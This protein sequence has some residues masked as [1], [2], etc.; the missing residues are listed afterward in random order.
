[1]TLPTLGQRTLAALTR[2]SLQ[3]WV[4]LPALVLALGA[5]RLMQMRWHWPA[6]LQASSAELWAVVLQGARFDLKVTASAALL[7]LPVFALVPGRLHARLA[8]TVAVLFVAASLVNLHY[9]GFYK[10]PIDAVVFGFFE[11][12]T[13]AILRT[14]WSDFPVFLTL[15]VL[16]GLSWFTIAGRRMLHDIATTTTTRMPAEAF[17]TPVRWVLVALSLLLLLL[18]MKGTL[19]AMP[20][21]RQN[22]T[23][24][25]SQFLNDMVPNGITALKFAWN[26]RRDSQNLSDPLVG[27]RAQ[28]YDS[29]QAAAQALGLAAGDEAALH[30]A[31]RMHA[32]ATAAPGA[33]KRKNLVLVL[34]E[35]WS[36]EPFLYQAADF[37]VLGRLAPTLKQGCHFS[38]FDAAQPGTHPTL[39]ALLFSTPI[40]PLTLGLQGRKPITWAVPH[41]LK[42]AGYHTLFVTSGRAGWR[43]LDRVLKVQG[44]DEVVD[45]S[46]L[47]KAYPEATLG[48]WGVW[49]SHVFRWLKEKLPATAADGKPVFVFVLTSTNH[50]PY[51]LPAN[52]PRVQRNPARWGGER[53]SDDLWP[54]LDTWHYA[55]DLLGDY[56]QQLRTSPLGPD[57]L[58]A[59]TG[60]HNVRSFGLYATADRRHLARQVP[61]MLWGEGLDCGP[62]LR[63]PASHRDIF[64]TLLPLL[65]LGEGALLTGRNLLADP[66]APPRQQAAKLNLPLSATYFGP[67]RSATGQW[68][69]GDPASFLCTPPPAAGA[70]ACGFDA[71]ADARLRAHLGLLDWTIRSALH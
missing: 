49:D 65:G 14:I 62:Q 48:I 20:L 11:D 39:E 70:S 28:G 60:D 1:M 36:A 57:T 45:A 10:T 15:A 43:E 29:P 44:F 41:L 51:D 38:N 69:L 34:M 21:G 66:A 59:A 58:I 67:A 9:F 53:N 55:T 68:T 37:E 52:H 22:T 19:R 56:V 8:G 64:P 30:Q 63:L 26:S 42:Q 25:P 2:A 31:L 32:P 17:S 12:D 50:P 27:L 46:V 47:Q 4:M 71:Q 33:A 35:S 23:V 5:L 3:A 13:V 61:F 54:N 40:T 16:T 24:T 6:G 7:L 18:A